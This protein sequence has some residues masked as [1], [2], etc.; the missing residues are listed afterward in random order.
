M[1]WM[2]IV[3]SHRPSILLADEG[4]NCA[5]PHVA[6]LKLTNSLGQDI[7]LRLPCQALLAREDIPVTPSKI[8]LLLSE[9]PGMA[10]VSSYYDLIVA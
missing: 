2:P 6:K 1:Q 4:N 3:A 5:L 9:L 10:W 7:P 8:L